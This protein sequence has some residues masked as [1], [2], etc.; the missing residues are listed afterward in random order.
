MTDI[1]TVDPRFRIHQGWLKLLTNYAFNTSSYRVEYQKLLQQYPEQANDINY[2]L[3]VHQDIINKTGKVP[4]IRSAAGLDPLTFGCFSVATHTAESLLDVLKVFEAYFIYVAGQLDL[5][6]KVSDQYVDLFLLDNSDPT[7]YRSTS[8]GIALVISIILETLKIVN[9]NQS[10]ACELFVRKI[11]IP[12]E[13]VEH[14]KQ[15]YNC[16]HIHKG[17][18]RKIRFQRHELD[19]KNPN[20]CRD[21]YECNIAA[22]RKVAYK[23]RTNDVRQQ[24]FAIFDQQKSLADITLNHVAH[25]MLTTP[26][27]LSRRLSQVDTTFKNLLQL[28]RM[29]K[30]LLLLSDPDV[31]NTE[32]AYQLGFSEL[33]SFSRAFKLWTGESPSDFREKSLKQY[34]AINKALL[35]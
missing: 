26:R 33:S 28:Y 18:V 4:S 34:D 21:T 3:Q 9:H 17:G 19:I 30:A 6:L 31:N 11:E 15:R 23:L 5:V 20:Y 2:V 13:E 16:R 14:F 27:T 10:I 22:V 29:Q 12:N 1:T 8:L 25:E 35:Y 32:V 24:I 7:S